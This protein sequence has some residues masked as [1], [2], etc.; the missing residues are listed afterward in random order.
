MKRP[1]KSPFNY[2]LLVAIGLVLVWYQS[3]GYRENSKIMESVKK[4]DTKLQDPKKNKIKKQTKRELKQIVNVDKNSVPKL[5]TKTEKVRRSKK[6]IRDLANN[7]KAKSVSKTYRG[8]YDDYF[9]D[10][11]ELSSGKF[12]ISSNLVAE[13]AEIQG[14]RVPLFKVGNF[15]IY[16]DKIEDPLRNHNQARVVYNL[17]TKKYAVLTGLIFIRFNQKIESDDVEKML[18]VIVKDSIDHLNLTI[19]IPQEGVSLIEI[20]GLLEENQNIEEFEIELLE[21]GLHEK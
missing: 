19:V 1:I 5:K 6:L 8:K 18:P 15:N 13:P 21:G 2:A 4:Q 10:N 14:A 17:S 9:Q 3:L 16:E 20:E 7:K 11:F 12:S